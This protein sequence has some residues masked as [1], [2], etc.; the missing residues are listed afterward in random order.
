MLIHKHT[1]KRNTTH[2]PHYK[3]YYLLLSSGKRY[4]VHRYYKK[5]NTLFCFVT[6][7]CISSSRPPNQKYL[8]S[9]SGRAPP[10]KRCLVNLQISVFAIA[11]PAQV[12]QCRR[13]KGTTHF[14]RLYMHAHTCTGTFLTLIRLSFWGMR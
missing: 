3:S 6:R 8:L 12:F 9:F 10:M 2:C 1:H 5:S 14:R 11:P 13:N 4:S 7:G